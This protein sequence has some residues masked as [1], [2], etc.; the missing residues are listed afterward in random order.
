MKRLIIFMLVLGLVTVFSVA[1]CTSLKA[2]EPLRL[3]DDQL[4]HVSAGA[5]WKPCDYCGTDGSNT[6]NTAS[7]RNQATCNAIT[8]AGVYNG[9]PYIGCDPRYPNTE[10]GEGAGCA[11]AHQKCLDAYGEHGCMLYYVYCYGDGTRTSLKYHCQNSGDPYS[12]EGALCVCTLDS[13]P[14]QCQGGTTWC[15]L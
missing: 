8:W 6:C 12:P 3:S 7:P 2:D 10:C 11:T 15:Y 14:T 4:D 9:N 1:I 5:I 13:S